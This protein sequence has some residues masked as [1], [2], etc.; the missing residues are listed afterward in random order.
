MV[1]WDVAFCSLCVAEPQYV[2]ETYCLHLQDRR[3]STL[4]SNVAVQIRTHNRPYVQCP[5]VPDC[6]VSQ[7]MTLIWT[8]ITAYTWNLC[9]INFHLQPRYWEGTV[10]TLTDL[11]WCWVL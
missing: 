4:L 6:T 10:W 11:P 7:Q 2:R 1:I 3:G 9:I 5:Y 8:L